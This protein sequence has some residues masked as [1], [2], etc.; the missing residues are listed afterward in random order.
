VLICADM[1]PLIIHCLREAALLGS[2][3]LSAELSKLWP[4]CSTLH[5]RRQPKAT[6]QMVSK[7]LIQIIDCCVAACRHT[8]HTVRGVLTWSLASS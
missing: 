4:P 1:P 5:S 8:G 3:A 7:H 2:T 6:L